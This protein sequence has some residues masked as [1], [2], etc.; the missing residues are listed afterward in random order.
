VQ[1][2]VKKT[3]E[4]QKYRI[5]IRR[6]ETTWKRYICRN[7]RLVHSSVCA[8]HD[9]ADRIRES[10]KSLDNIKRQQSEKGTVCLRSKTTTVLSEG[11]VPETMDVNLLQFYS[12]EIRKYILYKLSNSI[13]ST[14]ILQSF[15]CPLMVQSYTI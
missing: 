6:T 1:Y 13:Y 9:D 4:R 11:T 7:I 15:V 8:I 12:L 10:H 14:Y 5:E 3:S 2:K